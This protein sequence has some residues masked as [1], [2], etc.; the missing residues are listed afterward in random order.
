MRTYSTPHVSLSLP[1]SS[2]SHSTSAS[3]YFSFPSL[4]FPLFLPLTLPLSLPLS[5]LFLSLFFFLSEAVTWE[6]ATLRETVEDCIELLRGKVEWL[7]VTVIVI[8]TP[9]HCG[10][11]KS[12]VF[13]KFSLPSV[14]PTL[15]P[16]HIC[17]HTHTHT[18][19]FYSFLF[20]P[21][22]PYPPPSLSPYHLTSPRSLPSSS[23][24]PLIILTP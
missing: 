4:S 14:T 8:I 20:P 3:F 10:H 18:H 12:F 17:T 22:L 6:S 21:P 9:Y 7:T 15:H 1:F 24:S 19:K 2:T 11:R 23:P 16:P 13:T 5:L